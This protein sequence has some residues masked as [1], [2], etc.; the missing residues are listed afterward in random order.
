[1]G[2]KPLYVAFDPDGNLVGGG[3]SVADAAR[4]L[5][6]AG[7]T[8]PVEVEDIG[9]LGEARRNAEGTPAKA[10]AATGLRP[11]DIEDVMS[12]SV[13]E[14]FGRIKKLLA[15]AGNGTKMKHPPKTMTDPEAFI[16]ALLAG[17]NKIEK[18]G[19]KESGPLSR[20]ASV[21]II[22]LSLMPADRLMHFETVGPGDAQVGHPVG[23]YISKLES[24]GHL[25]Q[26]V[27]RH[28]QRQFTLCASSN[29]QCRETCLD[30]SGG[31]LKAAFTMRRRAVLTLALTQHPNE[32]VRL[33]IEAC[34]WH[35]GKGGKWLR[36][37]RLNVFSDIPWEL[38]TPWL[39]DE[40]FPAGH[41]YDYTKVSSRRPPTN[42]DL[43]FSFSGTNEREA[44][45]AI[46]AGRRVAVVFLARELRK[47]EWTPLWDPSGARNPKKRRTPVEPI[48]VGEMLWGAPIINGDAHDARPLDPPGA[49]SLAPGAACIAGLAFKAPRQAAEVGRV[50]D[51]PATAR[52]SEEPRSFIMPAYL[53]ED[54]TGVSRSRLSKTQSFLVTPVTPGMQPG[55]DLADEEAA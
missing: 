20:K 40:V 31:A 54:D 27:G 9:P 45:Q 41:F 19:M 53:L 11:L 4:E 1:M 22:G 17:N 13:D 18:D 35:F 34:R 3:T 37:V 21:D 28:G 49:L 47:G 12:L 33:L 50:F 43:T 26:P 14:A 46:A 7:F 29:K 55:V 16:D 32:F 25:G 52:A 6:H 44:Q 10:L 24:A 15:V 2:T 23:K 48:P 39:F 8:G 42:Y 36:F 5:S 30:F 51:R 38:L